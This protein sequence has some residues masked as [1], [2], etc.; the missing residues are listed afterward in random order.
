[1][2]HQA[3]AFIA[4]HFVRL[5][6]SPTAAAHDAPLV[7]LSCF[8]G[9]A[10]WTEFV[11]GRWAAD[12]CAYVDAV[13]RLPVD[14]MPDLFDCL[15]R[16]G[17]CVGLL[18][19][20]SNVILN[21]LTL[22][23]RRRSGAC[24]SPEES[25][26]PLP[27]D[28]RHVGNWGSIA[29]RSYNGLL[30]FMHT[31]FRYLTDD[32]ARFYL[33]LSGGDV[34]VAIRIAE[35]EQFAAVEG[36]VDQAVV[37]RHP[38]LLRERAQF[39]L[40]VAGIKAK[41]PMPDDLLLLFQPALQ[42]SADDMKAVLATLA[43]GRRLAVRDVEAILAVLKSQLRHRTVC[44][45]LQLTFTQRGRGETLHYRLNGQHGGGLHFQQCAPFSLAGLRSPEA[46]RRKLESCLSLVP[47]HTPHTP[48]E[49]ADAPPT[50]GHVE[51]L[52]MGLLD[53]IHALYVEAL[54]RLPR[55]ALRRLLRGVLVA[56][57]CYG[58]MD[59]V[60][61]I[62][63]HAAWYSV[64]AP[65][66]RPTSE[67]D[68]LGVDALLR[69]EVRSLA[70][71]VAAV[72]AATGFSEHQAVEHLSTNR[73]DISS[74]LRRAAPETRGPAFRRASEAARHPLGEHHSS[75]LASLAS[76]GPKFLDTVSSLLRSG[77][78]KAPRHL[79]SDASITE[80]Q[81]MLGRRCSPITPLPAPSRLDSSL[82]ARRQW[83]E[84]RQRFLRTELEQ[85]LRGYADQRPWEPTFELETICGVAKES[86]YLS[87]HCY[88]INFLAAAECLGIS[89]LSPNE[90]QLRIWATFQ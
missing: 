81:K 19:P 46:V 56:G 17:H 45:G 66:S 44:P 47:E 22:L 79:I 5:Q 40:A 23:C 53:V 70:G 34:L 57:H 38:D 77:E 78:V 73:C 8:H 11:R 35:L 89:R 48:A 75:F 7:R 20:A 76:S 10:K 43:E 2:I 68:V 55:A 50:C 29:F 25:C 74:M 72:R 54:A 88:H 39:A 31:Y 28:P 83:L 67:P 24:S 1:M 41:H 3:A 49:V 52:K 86:A 87:S 12:P 82:P 21:G 62:I 33:H 42:E 80:L 37:G 26:L 71:L 63:I 36:A 51:Y 30:A 60:S 58:P 9:D 27:P 4:R 6:P 15:Y 65:P 13:G 16:G 90:S 18:D 32:Q 14:E 69:L 61:N 85:L 64:I 84:K 59:P